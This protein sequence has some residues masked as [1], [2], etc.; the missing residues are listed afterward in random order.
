MKKFETLIRDMSANKKL[1]D[2]FVNFKTSAKKQ[3]EWL[4]LSDED[5]DQDR[6]YIE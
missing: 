1:Y 3:K 5:P 2:A 6:I 4:A